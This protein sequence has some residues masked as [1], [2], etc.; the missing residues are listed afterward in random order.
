MKTNLK[1][2]L[3]NL[4]SDGFLKRQKIDIG[5]IKILLK[6]AFK[7]FSSAEK[8]LKIDE[9]AAYISA[10]SSMMKLGRAL[11]YLNGFKPTDKH[12]HKTVV[13]IASNILG[14][15]F[16]ALIIKFDQMRR[17]RNQFTYDISMPLSKTDVKNAIKTAYD[18]F[19]TVRAEV[20]SNDPQL[21]L[22]KF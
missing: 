13:N 8:I 5:Q 7:N 2:Y 3:E 22:F 4:A 20:F 21:R 9:E 1:D 11:I 10:Y 16:D 18:F 15:E 12:Q 6:I 19:E 14:D 17:K